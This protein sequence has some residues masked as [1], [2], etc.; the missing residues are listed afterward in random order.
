M[1]AMSPMPGFQQ[2]GS[3]SNTGSDK[4]LSSP[5]S[6]SQVLVHSDGGRV[7]QETDEDATSTAPV[8]LPPT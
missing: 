7:P 2:G 5:P 4:P 6:S 3:E 8:E 1:T